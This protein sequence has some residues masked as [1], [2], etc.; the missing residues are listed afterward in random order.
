MTD[1]VA[2]S[3]V[4][5]RT[6]SVEPSDL[7]QHRV[8]L[9]GYCYR[10]LG[11][12]FEAEDAVQETMV[13]AWRGLDRFEGRS[14]LRSWLYRIATNVCFDMLEGRQR[15]AR[16]MDLGP[17]RLRGRPARRTAARGRP[18]SSRSP[19][20]S[21]LPADADPAERGRGPESDPAGVRRRAAA[22][23]AA[24]AGGAHP[25]RGAALAGRRGRRA[26]R[27]HGGVGEQRAAAGAGDA[28]PSRDPGQRRGR[29][30]DEQQRALLD[31]YVDAF[32]R[33]DIDALV[34]LLHED[35]TLSMP[36]YALWLRGREDIADVVAR[37]GRRLPGL[38]P[39]AA[40]RPTARRRSP[41]TARA[42]PAGRTGRGPCRSSDL[43]RPHRRADVLPVHRVA[44]PPLRPSR[45][46]GRA[47]PA[48]PLSPG[49]R[50]PGP[51]GGLTAPP[52]HR[53]PRSA[54]AG[55]ASQ[56]G[57]SVTSRALD[58]LG[59]FDTGHRRMSLTQMAVRAQMPMATA[60]RLVGDLVAW[61]RSYGGPTA[62]TR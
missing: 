58:L 46:P 17:A 19:T 5:L 52:H 42:D 20:A 34:A 61:V 13:R 56:P 8:E 28:R 55:G 40:P 7:E 41:S 1:L 15:R 25:A 37:S 53:T 47:G 38:P 49:T 31:R 11:S 54:V 59:S 23:A 48:R 26:A 4:S 22:P 33:Y 44:V 3:P 57:R 60:H 16:P 10:M 51:A 6:S 12:A 21:V 62:P 35:A 45:G 43:R 29:D 39:R 24:A 18:G 30:L 14:A 9:T 27:H 36:P 32:E 50:G 2:M